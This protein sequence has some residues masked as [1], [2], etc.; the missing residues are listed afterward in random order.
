MAGFHLS[1]SNASEH[2]NFN[3]GHKIF[4]KSALKLT[5]VAK[6]TE[7]SWTYMRENGV[8]LLYLFLHHS[9]CIVASLAHP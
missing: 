7:R 9:V 8:N 2:G 3:R 1:P 5:G 6:K 4:L